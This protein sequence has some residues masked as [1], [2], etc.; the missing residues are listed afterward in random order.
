MSTTSELARVVVAVTA[1]VEAKVEAPRTLKVLWRGV[2]PDTAKVE[3]AFKAPEKE[4][5]VPASDERKVAD[6][7]TCSV[8]PRIVA[9]ELVKV[10]EALMA[11]ANEEIPVTPKVPPMVALDVA[12]KVATF[13]L[14]VA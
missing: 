9:A 5:V 4:P 2:A 14:P 1:R 3:E 11:P 8:E 12:W 13:R 10:E 6:P 7:P